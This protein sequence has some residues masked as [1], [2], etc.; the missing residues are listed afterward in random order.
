MHSLFIDSTSGLD[1]GLLDNKFNWVEY[2]SLDEK[3][4]SEVIHT[5][6]YRLVQTHGLDLKNMRLFVTSGPGSY[7]GMRL[8]EGLAQIFE[9]SSLPVFSFLH[10]E[11]PKLTGIEAGFW[12][13][14]AFKGQ[15]FIY[16]WDPE[17]SHKQLVNKTDFKIESPNL[18]YTLDKADPILE[19]LATTKELIH[20]QSKKL[21]AEVLKLEMR[22]PPYYFR[23]LEEEFR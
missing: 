22:V 11:V 15:V 19:G 1:I 16:R 9:M 23:T 8:S 12:V 6:I 17:G 2:H 20:N 14:N 18:G 5:E 7:T 10:F 13:T 3:K 4:P 21:F